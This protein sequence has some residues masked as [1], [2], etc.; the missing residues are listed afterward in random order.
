ME[1]NSV[2]G[3]T[4]IQPNRGVPKPGKVEKPD[5][6][7]NRQVPEDK[8]VPSGEALPPPEIQRVEIAPGITQRTDLGSF[9]L[10]LRPW[11]N[12]EDKPEQSGPDKRI[13]IEA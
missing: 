11:E 8:F 2:G 3:P 1:I 7:R 9:P 4:P 5:E 6:I 12:I 13:D 10:A